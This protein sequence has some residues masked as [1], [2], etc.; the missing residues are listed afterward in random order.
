MLS[1]P[2]AWTQTRPADLCSSCR[3]LTRCTISSL[4]ITSSFG[5]GSSCLALRRLSL[6]IT[7][8]QAAKPISVRWWNKDLLSKLLSSVFISFSL[9]PQNNLHH[10]PLVPQIKWRDDR[11]AYFCV[12]GKWKVNC[13][14]VF[15]KF[16]SYISVQFTLRYLDVNWLHFPGV[17]KLTHQVLFFLPALKIQ[18]KINNNGLC[19]VSFFFF[20]ALS[21]CIS[22]SMLHIVS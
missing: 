4:S 12:H 19:D 5:R 20:F 2:L 3:P 13:M 22:F 16:C 18:M 6:P 17:D 1:F 7:L 21:A 11:D 15:L 8:P 14:A 10:W 9:W